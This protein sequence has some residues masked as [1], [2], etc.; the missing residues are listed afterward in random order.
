MADQ[1]VSQLTQKTIIAPTDQLYSIDSQSKRITISDWQKN[2]SPHSLLVPPVDSQFS[3]IN[4]NGASVSSSD[5]GICMSMPAAGGDNW[6]VREK[7]IPGTPPWQ[8]TALLSHIGV[9]GYMGLCFRNNGAG[10]LAGPFMYHFS[11]TNAVNSR[12]Y[13]RKMTSPTVISAE[14]IADQIFTGW[15]FIWIRLRDDGVNRLTSV[16][17]D[18]INFL[19][20][21][22]I[23]RTDF[24]TADRVG[25]FGN[26]QNLASFNTL[27]TL[28]SWKE[29][30][31]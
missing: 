2:T 16:S 30:T 25:W 10:T 11:T 17:K 3:W 1:K 23:A 18:G 12:F 20:I 15:D 26:N 7:A 8:V 9:G 24:L 31:V 13:V 21:H 28:H 6:R 4:Q 5:V 29:E 22:S 27:V 19:Q 14:Y